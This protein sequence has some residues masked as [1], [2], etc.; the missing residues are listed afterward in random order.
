MQELFLVVSED[1]QVPSR[2]A[3]QLLQW[4]LVLQRKPIQMSLPRVRSAA[5]DDRAVGFVDVEQ[6]PQLE[7]N[8][9]DGPHERA[10]RRVQLDL[11]RAVP[12]RCPKKLAAI[13][14]PHW[15]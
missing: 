7:I 10:I 8:R 4:S 14:A 9:R 2:F 6:L 12:F 5:D 11:P 1:R 15:H 3:R 13:F